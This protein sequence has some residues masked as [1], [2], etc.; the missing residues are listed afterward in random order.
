VIGYK[1]EFILPTRAEN[2]V[3]F[4]ISFMNMITIQPPYKE[5]SAAGI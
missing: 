1:L 3:F 4:A 2:Y 5:Y